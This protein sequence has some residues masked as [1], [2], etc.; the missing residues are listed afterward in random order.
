[1][2]IFTAVIGALFIWSAFSMTWWRY[3]GEVQRRPPTTSVRVTSLVIGI[4]ATIL[5][6]RWPF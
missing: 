3:K 5:S 4:T 6:L 1:M 2:R